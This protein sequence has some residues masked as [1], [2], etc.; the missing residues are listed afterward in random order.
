MLAAKRKKSKADREK[1]AAAASKK[2][3]TKTEKRF[4]HRKTEKRKKKGFLHR[5]NFSQG[6]SRCQ[7]RLPSHFCSD[8]HSTFSGKREN[9]QCTTSKYILD[10][11]KIITTARFT[12]FFLNSFYYKVSWKD[13]KEE[14]F[15]IL[16]N[17]IPSW[18]IRICWEPISF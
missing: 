9:K 15:F 8:K 10:L 2:V 3:W 4:L 18:W 16:L 14:F 6:L 13:T 12:S 1:R 17:E 7:K 11:R 5:C